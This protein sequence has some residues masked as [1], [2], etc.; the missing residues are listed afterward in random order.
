VA[1][2]D[3]RVGETLRKLRG[4]R[5]QQD[6]AAY[7]REQG[8]SKWSQS[9]VWSVEKGDRPL[10][11][12]EARDLA[13][14]LGVRLEDLTRN[15]DQEV[16]HRSHEVERCLAALGRELALLSSAQE[17][18]E[19]AIVERADATTDPLPAGVKDLASM[20]LYEA[21]KRVT[22]TWPATMRRYIGLDRDE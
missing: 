6:V 21:V 7:M 15:V 14:F 11:L 17:A 13:L 22:A 16:L 5:S 1:E 2:D 8:W 3:K 20:T 4:D 12:L 10:R 19:A 9:T 18:L